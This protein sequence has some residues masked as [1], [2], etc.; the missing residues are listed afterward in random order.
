MALTLDILDRRPQRGDI[1]R[2]LGQMML[3]QPFHIMDS[4]IFSWEY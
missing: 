4:I 3:Q 2:Q 1:Q